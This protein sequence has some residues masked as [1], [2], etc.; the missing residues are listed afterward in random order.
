MSDIGILNDPSS[1]AF[2]ALIFGSPGLLLGAVI[3]AVLWRGH[4]F[5][6]AGIGAVAG[7]ALWLTG[8]LWWHDAL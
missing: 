7:F 5:A 8:L 3:G 1:L 4:R 6:G 2:L